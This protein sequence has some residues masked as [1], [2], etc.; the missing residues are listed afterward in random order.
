MI[1]FYKLIN[2]TLSVLQS[3]FVPYFS[4]LLEY[5]AT[6]LQSLNGADLELLSEHDSGA[7][8][9]QKRARDQMTRSKP[10]VV[11]G[12]AEHQ[13]ILLIV[14]ALHLCFTHDDDGFMQEQSKFDQIMQ[15]LV[16]QLQNTGDEADDAQHL[17]KYSVRAKAV[18]Q[19]LGKLATV[20][21]HQT[22]KTLQYQ[23]LVLT[24]RTSTP[25]K[26]ASIGALISLYTT[27]GQEFVS[28]LPEMLPYIAE[29]LEDDDEVVVQ[30]T[31]RL[32]QKV[33]ETCGE[34]LSRYMK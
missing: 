2:M 25:V 16:D 17:A 7:S 10:D 3:I 21:P 32:V 34:D 11:I 28:M 22:W 13:C 5:C 14:S 9:G 15:P 24:Q 6:D 29:L 30:E 18:A 1:M 33:E 19:C 31:Q 8:A 20:V 26:C 27:V 12:E 4:L 23:V